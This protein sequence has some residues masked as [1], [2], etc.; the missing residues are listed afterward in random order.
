MKRSDVIREIATLDGLIISNIGHPSRELYAQQ[1]SARNF[2]MLGSMG[3]ASSVGLGVACSQKK[4]VYVIDGDGALL[5]NLGSLATIA[6][7][8]PANYCLIIVDNKAYGSTGNQRTY[9]AGK[10]DLAKIAKGAG[11]RNVQKVKTISALRLALKKCKGKC[12]IV[13]AETGTEATEVPIIPHSA[14]YIKER[15]VREIKKT[16]RQQT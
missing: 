1:D 2:Y 5:M 12:T 6:H 3:L 8:A 11:N 9:T 10:T 14:L 7:H 15:F 16:N 13:V 4:R